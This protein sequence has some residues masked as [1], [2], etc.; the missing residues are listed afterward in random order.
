MT[1]APHSVL[2]L[3]PSRDGTESPIANHQY[4]AVQRVTAVESTAHQ[5]RDEEAVDNKQVMIRERPPPEP[6]LAKKS[7]ARPCD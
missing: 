6:S 5:Q 2:R 3:L 7:K 4:R 1:P